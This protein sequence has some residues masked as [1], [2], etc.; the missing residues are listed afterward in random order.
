[1]DTSLSRF[2]TIARQTISGLPPPFADHVKGIVLHVTQRPS[3]QMLADLGLDDPMA[4]TGLYDGVPLTEKS[5][6]DPAP[7][8]DSI[9]IFREPILTE[10]QERP[11]VTLEELVSHVMVHELAHHFGWSDA[12]IAEIDRWWE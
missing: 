10:L 12:D 4:L 3:N 8:P 9:W 1:M 5:V 6:S 2:E 11:G 7:L